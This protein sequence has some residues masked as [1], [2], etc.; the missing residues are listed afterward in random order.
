MLECMQALFQG[1][2]AILLGVL[3]WMRQGG[4]GFYRGC[5]LGEGERAMFGDGGNGGAIGHIVMHTSFMSTSA[6]IGRALTFAKT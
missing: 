4:L 1:Q 2:L 5:Y 3:G 6:D